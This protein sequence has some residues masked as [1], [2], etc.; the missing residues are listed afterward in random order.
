MV[1]LQAKR[2]TLMSECLT[3]L[4]L[5][6]FTQRNSVADF[7]QS[8]ILY[9]KRPFCGFQPPSA[10]RVRYKLGVTMHRCLNNKSTAVSRLLRSSLRHHQLS[11][12]T[13]RTL[14]LADRTTPLT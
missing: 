1:F 3:T 6:V 11:A 13:F 4:S 2:L 12:T 14:L 5:T 8:A 10:D 9:G 7:K